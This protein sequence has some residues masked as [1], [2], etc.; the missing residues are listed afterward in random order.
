MS[1]LNI[2]KQQL[3]KPYFDL[4]F[5]LNCFR[6]VLIENDKKSWQNSSPG[7][8]IRAATK[9]LSSPKNISICFLLVFSC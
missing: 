7:F 5:L 4:E 8:A 3:G 1:Q 9:I 6:E 2:L